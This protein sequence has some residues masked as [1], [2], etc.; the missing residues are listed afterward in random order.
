MFNHEKSIGFP[1]QVS[2]DSKFLNVTCCHMKITFEKFI[3]KV[4]QKLAPLL[5]SSIALSSPFQFGAEWVRELCFCYRRF[6]FFLFLFKIKSI[7]PLLNPFFLKMF[8]SRLSP[9]TS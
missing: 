6:L 9:H 3:D 2:P 8:S 1:Y 4:L 7:D 5:E